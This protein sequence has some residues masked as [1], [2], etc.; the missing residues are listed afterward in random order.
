VVSGNPTR[1]R[2]SE[3]RQA[4]IEEI[5]DA[6]WRQARTEGLA[7]LSLRALADEVGMRP[8]SLYSYFDSKHAIYDAMYAQGCREFAAA[9]S[10]WVLT[11]DLRA[12]LTTIGRSFVDFCTS[13]PVRYQLVF[14]RTIPGFEP[15]AESYAVAQESLGS[16]VAHLAALGIDDPGDVDLFTALG[17]GLTDQQISNDPGGDRWTRLVDDAIEMFIGHVNRRSRAGATTSKQVRTR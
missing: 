6:A 7:G 11:R 9:Q 16:I 13:D 8:Q 15:S 3:R 2:R 10:A 1:D 14:Q 17:T 4:T 12:D 5:L